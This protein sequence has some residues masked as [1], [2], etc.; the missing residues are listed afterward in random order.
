MFLVSGCMSKDPALYFE[1]GR[2]NSVAN[3]S[4]EYQTD[5]EHYNV[6]DR[7][8]I[9]KDGRGD[10]EDYAL[11]KQKLLR[12]KGIKSRI[13]CVLTETGKHHVVLLVDISGVTYVLDNR[14]PNLWPAERYD[15]RWVSCAAFHGE[16]I[17]SQ[18]QI[19]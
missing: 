11:L 6:P 7:W 8:V 14:Y 16:Y 1:V 18:Q 2:I 9:P 15:Y 5:I 19:P 4:I 3:L 13:A 10:C 12:D 17:R